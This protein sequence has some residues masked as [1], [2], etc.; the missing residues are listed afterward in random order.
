MHAMKGLDELR[1]QRSIDR[2]ER[3]AAGDQYVVKVPAGVLTQNVAD[4]RL[5]APPDAVALDRPSHL[6]ADSKAEPRRRLR[7]AAALRLQDKGGRCPACTAA[8]AQKVRPPLE[9]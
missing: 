7:A 3:W 6:L 4:R 8:H 2:I 5:E 9:G 1:Y